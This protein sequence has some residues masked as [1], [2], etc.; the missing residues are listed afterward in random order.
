MIPFMIYLNVSTTVIN[1][2]HGQNSNLAFG[3]N[4]TFNLIDDF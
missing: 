4:E 3:S 1:L 2:I